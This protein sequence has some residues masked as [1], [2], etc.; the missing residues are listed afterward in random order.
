MNENPMEER[1]GWK[2]GWER[3]VGEGGG[4]NEEKEIEN[5]GQIAT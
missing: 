4:K 1:G 2:M 5:K 3:G